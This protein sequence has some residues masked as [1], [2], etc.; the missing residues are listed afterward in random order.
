[1]RHDNPLKPGVEEY[2]SEN[3]R[4]RQSRQWVAVGLVMIDHLR[5]HCPLARADYLSAE[6]GEIA[7]TRSGLTAVL[8]RYGV[9]AEYLRQATSRS[10]LRFGERIAEL[11]D[12]GKPLVGMT[13]QRR[14]ECLLDAAAA[15]RDVALAWFERQNLRLSFDRSHSPVAWMRALLTLSAGK[16]GG[17]VE[18]HLVGAKLERRHPDLDVPNHPGHAA[19]VQTGR[20]GDFL[21]GS[22]VYHITGAVGN[23][24][25]R[26]CAENARQ[27]LHPVLLVPSRDVVKATIL[28]EAAGLSDLLTI[29]GI[30][31]FVALNIVE[32]SD[33][34]RDQFGETF[35]AIV[36]AYNRRVEEVESDP[37]L[38]I[39][40][41]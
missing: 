35:A 20:G 10:N 7:N 22:T 8:V 6:G 15:L 14:D 34:K 37:A 4:G 1:M 21:V 18:Q 36:A 2:I 5:K 28:A 11:L 32:L 30:E 17:R 26:K 16:S 29:W 25:L 38:R 27:S 31:E 40:L 39:D 23:D 19:D 41:D 24:V 12:Y 13:P 33:G 9:P 3:G